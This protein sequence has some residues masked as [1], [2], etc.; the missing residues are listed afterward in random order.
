MDTV[1]ESSYS[2]GTTTSTGDDALQDE[3]AE[4][5]TDEDPEL[6]PADY[7]KCVKCNNSQNNPL[8]RY[9]EKCYQVRLGRELLI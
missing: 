5:S 9:C 3:S 2:S 6:R 7:W 1:L 8:Y 4:D